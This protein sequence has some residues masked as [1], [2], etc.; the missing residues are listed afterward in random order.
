[1]KQILSF[2]LTAALLLACLTGCGEQA[3]GTAPGGTTPSG[4]QTPPASSV[5]E[6]P[7]GQGQTPPVSPDPEGE[8]AAR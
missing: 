5:P 8:V 6:T 2:G 1:M 7:A 3:A 4:G